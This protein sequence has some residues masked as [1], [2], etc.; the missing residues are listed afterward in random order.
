MNSDLRVSAANAARHWTLTGDLDLASAA[1][2]EGVLEASFAEPG[3]ITLDGSGLTFVDSSGI[4]TL[5]RISLRLGDHSLII[6]RPSAQLKRL[7]DLTGIQ[8]HGRIEMRDTPC[9]T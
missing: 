8:K 7:F 5:I 6:L 4:R 3:N 9:C 2:L 1:G